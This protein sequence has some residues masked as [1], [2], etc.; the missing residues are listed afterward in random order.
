MP[1]QLVALAL[2]MG[3]FRFGEEDRVL[4]EYGCWAFA[5]F[6]GEGDSHPRD[7]LFQ[8]ALVEAGGLAAIGSAVEAHR[9]SAPLRRWGCETAGS[10]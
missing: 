10:G 1:S 9:D 7:F 5:V 2:D 6:T 8:E 3:L 4:C